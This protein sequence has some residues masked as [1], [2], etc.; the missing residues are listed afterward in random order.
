MLD[1]HEK[2]PYPIIAQTDTILEIIFHIAKYLAGGL[3][4]VMTIP[5]ESNPSAAQT[6]VTVPVNILAFDGDSRKFT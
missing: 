4:I 6:I 2:N 3:N 1:V 5:A